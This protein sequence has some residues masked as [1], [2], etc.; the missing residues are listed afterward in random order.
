MENGKVLIGV[1]LLK[2]EFKKEVKQLEKD[3]KQSG[4]DIGESM[5]SAGFSS[6]KLTSAMRKASVILL[7]IGAGLLL[8][9]KSISAMIKDNKELGANIEYLGFVT[10]TMINNLLVAIGNKFKPLIEYIL[11]LIFQLLSYINYIAKAWFNVDL[12][13]NASA[14]AFKRQSKELGKSNKEAK[15]L[16][17][18]LLG[19]DK[20]N[21]LDSQKDSGSGGGAGGGAGFTMPTMT[22]PEGDVPDWVKWIAENR[23]EILAVIAGLVVGLNALNLGFSGLQSLGI[24]LIFAGL[25][26]AIEGIV[27]FIKDPSWENFLTILEGIA[28]IVAGIAILCGAWTVALVALGVAI[29][30]YVI[31][32]WDKVKAV[33]QKAESWINEKLDWLESKTY[34]VG[35]YIKGVWQTV[36][37]FMVDRF[38]GVVRPIKNVVEG[39]IKIFKGDLKGGIESV[40]KGIGNFFIGVL[41]KVIDAANSF[42]T[43]FRA[44]IVGVG[45]I[46]GKSWTMDNI[47]IPR[48]NY[49]SRG[50]IIV[51]R[52]GQGVP[53]GANTFGGEE[54]YE[55]V[56][57][58]TDESAMSRLGLEIGKHITVN[59]DVTLELER[60]VLARVMKEIQGDNAFLGNGG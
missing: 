49:L 27:E 33:L 4:Q 51:N 16:E 26:L 38:E 5:E 8:A 13:A 55:G 3:A 12:F 32:N 59:A 45:K 41:N 46:L 57:P 9:K 40:I 15:A 52:P 29:T 34:F 39:I 47:K 36:R 18:T 54:S 28:L 21:K 17:K 60:R 30:A 24:G 6:E 44:I 50:G 35:S 43:P 31:K 7:Q 11:S 23:D 2:K 1:K 58:L 19:F 56:L 48:A 10:S 25:L 14:D 42:F 53:V 22:L 20:I 37:D